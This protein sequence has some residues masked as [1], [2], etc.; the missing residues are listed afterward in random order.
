[1]RIL[2]AGT[3][4]YPAL[5]GQAVFT[6]HLTEG[7][8]RQGHEVLSVF[9]SEKGSAYHTRRNGVE[10]EALKSTN[11]NMIHSDTYFSLFSERNIEHIFDSFEPEIV[12]IQ[13]HFPLSRD[14]VQVARRRK[15]RLIGTNHF[16]PENL[17]AYIPVISNVKPV[18][19]RIM[20][21]WMLDVYNRLGVATAQSKASANLM[22]AQG[23]R[24]PVYPVSCGIDLRRFHLDPKIDREAIRAR[25]GIDPKRTI[26]LF[27]GRVDH[28]KCLDVL[29]RAISQFKRDD[30]QLVIAG[31]GAE[32]DKLETLAQE[33]EL[34]E[35]VHFAGFI[36]SEDLPALL[37]SVDIFTMPS[38]AELLSI[39]SL[40]AMACGRPVLLANAVAL[41][42]LVTV[43][44]NGYLFEPGN[45]ADAARCMA[46][47]ADHP[48]NWARMG[49]ASLEKARYHGMENTIRQ[50][51]AIY[52]VLLQDN[53]VLVPAV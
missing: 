30:M 29:L 17:A 43:G 53:P 39:A 36:P 22:K 37:N 51:E 4:N 12:H 21:L 7:L 33:L 8:A 48:E 46:L 28:E 3:V 13:D 14:V 25:F 47:L 9:P 24:I 41:P 1:M 18:Y 40:E 27:V 2:I 42:E 32:R 45:P 11:L 19:N 6:E 44:V 31:H 10:I 5:N 49:L 34:G 15:L 35:R 26:F 50:Y 16:M 38:Q 52:S 23:L 20:W